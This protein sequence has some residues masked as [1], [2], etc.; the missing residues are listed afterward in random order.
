M[1][2]KKS[3]DNGE[4]LYRYSIRKYHFG[5]ASVAIAAL[6]F[7]ANGV[8]KA[9]MAVSPATANT[10][11][12]GVP[13][14]GLT[15]GVP[16]TEGHSEKS[17]EVGS[18]K[19][20]IAKKSVDK[21]ALNQALSEL[22]A[23]IAKA[24]EESLLSLSNQLSQLTDE[25]KRLLDGENVSEEAIASQVSRVQSFTE[26]VR[27]LKSKAKDKDSNK[28][29][30]T[31]SK[32]QDK[33]EIKVSDKAVIPTDQTEEIKDV[34]KDDNKEDTANKDKLESL[35]KSLITYLYTA[36]KI[37][38]PE[39]KKFLEGVEEVVRSVENG[40]KNPQLTASEIEEL[41]KKGK[42]A[43]KKLALAIA[44][45][46]SGKR[47]SDNG[48]RMSSDSYFRA[49]TYYRAADGKV[50][51]SQGDEHLTEATV[52]YITKANDGSGYPPGTF[53]YISH[54]DNSF[55]NG[56]NNADLGQQPVKRLKQKVFAEVTKQSNGYHWKITYNNARESRQNPIYYF[57]IP[58]GQSVRN[59]K[60]FENGT[61]VKQGG[62]S[63]VF[64]GASDK[65]L[66]S[67]GSP[68]TGVNGTAYY[69]NVAN[70]QNAIVGNRGGIYGLD[71]FVKNNTEVYF[72]RNG[73][74]EE[75]KIVT[76]KL[77]DKIKNSTQNVFAF[78]P[79]DFDRGNTYVVEFDTVGDTED[80]LYYIAGMKSYEKIPTGRFMHK[81]YQQWYGV[82][83]RYNITVDTNR[84]KTTFLKGTGI[85]TL[86]TKA[87][88]ASSAVTIEDTYTNTRFNPGA[89]DIG[90]Y[91]TY[92][93][94][95]NYSKDYYKQFHNRFVRDFR[96]GEDGI[97]VT[98]DR[99][100]GNH[101]LYIEADV[102]NQKI[103]F[104][105]PYKVVTQ[106]DIY[107][108]VAKAV[109]GVKDYTGNLGAASDYIT[110][111]R[112]N[113]VPGFKEP[114]SFD[115]GT[116]S[117]GLS[118][119]KDRI[120]D[121]P[122]TSARIKEQSVKSVEWAGG[123]NDLTT[124][125]RVIEL[126]V[127]NGRKELFKV[128]YDID[129]VPG[130]KISAENVEKL[131]AAIREAYQKVD[132]NGNVSGTVPTVTSTTPVWVQKQIKVTYYDNENNDRTNNQDDSVD[133]VDVLFKQ[134]RKEATPTAPA[135]SVPEDGSASVTPKGNTD[136]LVVSY[137]PTD[138]NTDTII[139]VKKSGTTWGAVDTL[140]NGVTVNPSNGVVSITEPTVKDLSTITAK[141]TYL[142]SDE[143]SA[144]D[145]VK[146]PDNVAPTVSFNGKALTPNADD[147]RFIIYRGANFNP[148]FSVHDNKSDVNLSIT[149]LPK[150]IGVLSTRGG[151]DFNY[152]I[153]AN[154]V[155]NDAS[156]VEGTATVVATDARNNTATYKFKY[157]V[158]DLQ[159]SNS[160][161]SPEVGD[162]LGDAHH[163]LKVA[164]SNTRDTDDYYPAGMRF[165]W[166]EVNPRTIMVSDVPD[167]SKLNKIGKQ[168][169][170]YATAVFPN[171]GINDKNI[172]IN[173]KSASY[174]IYSGTTVP[175]PVEFNVRPKKPTLVAEQFYGTAGTKPT[176]TVGN[177]PTD[178]QLQSG[179]T[180]KVELYQG[181]TKVASKTV[182]DRS[183]TTTLSAT[184]FTADL[185]E[186]QQ[187]HAVVKVTG[188]QGVTAYD[189]SSA[190]SDNRRVTGRSALLN[191]ATDK[192]V[193]QVQDFANNRGGTLSEAEKNKIK[194]AIFEANKN[195]VLKGKQVSDIT[196]SDTGLITALDKDNK[197]AELQINPRNNI[198]T[199]FA[200]IRDDYNITFTNKG[201]PANRST[202][203]GFEW[204]SDH[205]S[206]IYKF[207]ATSGVGL[208]VNE[209][210]KTIT[211]TPKNPQNQPSLTTVTGNDKALGEANSN[212]FS[213]NRSTG[214]FSKNGVGVNV[215]DL[216]NPTSYGGGGNID[217][218]TNKL[219]DKN[220]TGLNSSNVGTTLGND[221]ISAANGANA[222][223]LSNVVKK[224]NG[225]DSLVVRKQLYLMPKYT[226]DQLLQ[227]RGNTNANNT[228]VINV[229]FV[230]V[231]P[232]AP[233]VERST[234]NTLATT[235]AQASRLADN[236]SFAGLAKV[237]DNYDKDDVTS[238]SS[239][240][241]RSKLNMWVKKGDTKEQIVANGVENTAVINRL[242]KEIDPAT[243]EVIAKTTDA[244]GNKSHEDNS[245]GAS[246]GFF[247]VG[248]NLVARETINV[249]QG[250]R[251]TQD[252]L[253]KLIQVQEGNE[254][255]DLPQGAT[256]TATLDTATIANG[257]EETKIAEATVDFGQGRTKKLN[258]RYRVL[259]TFPVANL[260][261]DFHGQP[262]GDNEASY[263]SNTRG[264]PSGMDWYLKKGN[265]NQPTSKIQDYLKNDPIGSTEY[266]FGA[267]YN[268]GR[269]TNSPTADDKLKHEGRLVH[270]VFDVMPNPTKVTVD[271][272][273]TLSDTQAKDAV[274]KVANS[275]NL[276]EGTIYEW[277]N[278]S[279]GRETA[280][281]T[282][283]GEQTFYVKIT[284]PKSQV[285]G[286]DLPGATQV[287]QSKV[288]A[289]TVN[290]TPPKPTFDTAPVT[291]T[292]RTITGTL[293]GLN[294][295]AGKA[296]VRVALN[297]G[298][299]R[300]LTS[301]NNG[302]VTISGNTWTATLPND[303]KLRQSVQKNGENVKPAN[304][305]VTTTIAGTQLSR[306]GDDKVV[307][308]GSYAITPA[309]AG[310]KHIDIT[311]PHDA[312]RVELRFHNSEENGDKA[313]SIVL[314]RSQNGGDWHVD[315]VRTDHTAVSDANKFVAK[316]ENGV[317]RTNA[318]ENLVRIHLKEIEGGSKL[319]LKEE[320][321]NGSGTS[322]YGKGL[323]LRV[324]YQSEAGQDPVTAGNWMIANI[325][326][327]SPTLEYKGT[328]GRSDTTR[329][330]FPS[331]TS[332]T[333]EKL[334]ELVTIR[335]TE[336][337]H[338]ILED[339]PYGTGSLQIMSGLTETPG[340]A[341]PAGRYTVVLKA[342]DSQGKASNELTLYVEVRKQ[343]DEHDPQA[344]AQEVSH[345][346]DPSAEASVN[347][348]G[349]PEGTTYKWKDGEKPD[350][351]TPGEKPGTVIV[352]YPDG[353]EDEVTVTV[354]VKE[355]KDEYTPVASTPNQEVS[356]KGDPSAE[357][358]VNTKGLPEGTTYKWK[359][360]E[361]PDTNTPGEK[362]GTVI[363]HYPDGTEDEVTVTVKV[364]ETESKGEP[365]VQPEIPEFNGGV[366]GEPEVQAEN[367][368]YNG[369]IG[370]TGVDENGNL[371]APPV[372]DLPEFTGGVNGELP[373]PTEL[374]NIQLII[375]KWVDEKGHDLK[376]AD[377]KAPNVLGEA[378]E[379]FEHGE[380]EGYVFVRTETKGDV[381]TH[382]F[383][384]VS[385][386]RPTG[387][388]HQEPA[389]P[390]A[391]TNPRL[392]NA[393]PAET[394]A[395][396][397]QAVLPNTGTQED[398]A[399]DV[400]G[401]L[402]L[403]GTVGLLF[404]KKK[405]D[406]E[407]E[408]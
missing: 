103:N 371:I 351:N 290:V 306:Q 186:G 382:I 249:K 397:S 342:I 156:F 36:K 119:Y 117:E 49:A 297:D 324:A 305:T 111:Y 114:D 143:S 159:T 232:T 231:D 158:V 347:T 101:T 144:R 294:A 165:I 121:F 132:T 392:N 187:V 139:T 226:N 196:I 12:V 69:Q 13:V 112:Y 104:R 138:Q 155:A 345:K 190:D 197:I 401:V 240:T 191:L 295:S 404:A 363:V 317:S 329:K 27:L 180:V 383:R 238:P 242:K 10:E 216:V 203:P 268:A 157:R 370:T 385:P 58:T 243:Y 94:T 330:V 346:G 381:V 128:P 163:Y 176:V 45:E 257:G 312:K 292:S 335:D 192:L 171:S 59:M 38:R 88:L 70:V 374:P 366:N 80:P 369:P 361:K 241:V 352:H 358:S 142:N 83:E 228:N 108:P 344:K 32:V 29:D 252:E 311:V 172:T 97:N 182:T 6:M 51:D 53:L 122:K 5:A 325:S 181:T 338:T 209:V 195:G 237:T 262:R 273:A 146:T 118:F 100:K 332:I 375:T 396:Q 185:T 105:L 202:D 259:R 79:R 293:G 230:P 106:S 334:A 64:N 258:I 35:S 389:T 214:Y 61:V 394:S 66:T 73:M 86:D 348:K 393:T 229:Y 320:V 174:K 309:I 34:Q 87:G 78:R 349:L 19:E 54:N 188:G 251:L 316:I 115:M 200:H 303:V 154:P 149:G 291:S 355:Q 50:Y 271:Q 135:I 279:G 372:V 22:Q 201:K 8:A 267:K 76:D 390:S 217:N 298:S 408:A 244:S 276:P 193:V 173:N 354:K 391:D 48:K 341:T 365:D 222:I 265:Q 68:D 150:G 3:N 126:T 248:Y 30:R 151:K 177:L 362:P 315:A 134:I 9:D 93:S 169:Q 211:A 170:Y 7:F 368:G 270:K 225:T 215:L 323:G 239:N 223:S 321:A 184:D 280:R 183:G 245:D 178:A 44:R 250:E 300:V 56:R 124:G 260:V 207:D 277:V 107:Q 326:N 283:S 272:G 60:L 77:Y 274:I 246:L 65:Y 96:G 39:T 55:A 145:T 337:N 160:P 328:E 269:F 278:A 398:R 72:N 14:T 360:G 310:S 17:Q 102:R 266:T 364:K 236:P 399:T 24:D 339:K 52:G 227:D 261:Y 221:S 74:T 152:T 286:S 356:H 224:A 234:T 367:P 275:E 212:G 405:K 46:H 131:N 264:L 387:D 359:D 84:L 218:T 113:P 153:P 402:S 296:V 327:T 162:S 31:D 161:A 23:A 140:P 81:S 175:K 120:F 331:G 380:I 20:A 127:E 357:A 89:R 210:L 255:Q 206:L 235:S 99:S 116:P 213:R 194:Q 208:D 353:T 287:Q 253:N 322:T 307:Q 289:V 400:L 71:D 137:R 166:K 263:Y 47:D 318:S 281:A 28:E 179:A 254:R 110:E 91:N 336:D 256:V 314:V 85:G 129:V 133:Y 16:P 26:Q 57:T 43:E 198:V 189:V 75:D 41:M 92:K 109:T 82:Q 373:E 350:T 377:A 301:E 147:T 378:N 95:G 199:R 284:L 406:D 90:E 2:G 40:L 302:G 285:T 167:G 11:K 136:K 204:S 379:A 233:R 403:I 18:E 205:K 21:S 388:D 25:N 376:P 62:I 63:E 395:T 141:A 130:G 67:V 282:T 42:Q 125:T 219:V 308:M 386:A 4:K 304:L 168:T 164:E 319:H 343:R 148:T 313:N 37:E 1:F 288:I 123:T 15:E 247:K 33:K 333:K 220:R 407:E 299:G 340:K 384:K 98:A